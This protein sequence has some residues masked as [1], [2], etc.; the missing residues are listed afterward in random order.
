MFETLL[1][2]FAQEAAA[3]SA[4]VLRLRANGPSFCV[5]RERGG[6]DV[7]SVRAES[8]RL[9][10]LKRMLRRTPLITIAEVQGD[11]LGF[12]FGLA[13][14]C[15]FALV[16]QSATLAFPEMRM[17]LAPAA[18]MAY[19][20]EFTLP[21]HAFPLVLFGDSIPPAR[22]RDIGLVSDVFA[23][24]AAMRAASEELTA[25]ILKLDPAATRKC[26]E[27]FGTMLAGSFEANCRL[28]IDALTVGSLAIL[29]R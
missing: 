7:P 2:V 12:G 11:A 18:I 9:I 3:P 15:D 29:E 24:A 20:G 6:R 14:L 1:A 22:A 8:A 10:E 27:L 25:R 21:R 28:A 17:G 5:G 16:V 4:R 19:L 13:I 26:K 23:D